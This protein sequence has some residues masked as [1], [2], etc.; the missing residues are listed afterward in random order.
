VKKMTK[1]YDYYWKIVKPSD[2][3]KSES[4]VK[5]V[6]CILLLKAMV[7]WI[8]CFWGIF[9]FYFHKSKII[10]KLWRLLRLLPY[11]GIQQC[12]P[13]EDLP[14]CILSARTIELN[15]EKLYT[16]SQMHISW[17]EKLHNQ[18]DSATNPKVG[19]TPNNHTAWQGRWMERDLEGWV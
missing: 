8:M 4:N 6:I 13:K 12:G 11:H 9:R 14:F 1:S 19:P 7:C 3:F 16:H 17:I 2:F 18:F 10:F 5:V 15:K